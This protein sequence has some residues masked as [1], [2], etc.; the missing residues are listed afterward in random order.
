MEVYNK[1]VS[2]INPVITIEFSEKVSEVSVSFKGKTIRA[3]SINNF[4]WEANLI[5][6]GLKPGEY[7]ININFKTPDLATKSEKIVIRIKAG[8]VEEDLFGGE[9]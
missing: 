2:Y 7:E 5:E 8:M 1:E 6:L 9:F 3:K 4:Q